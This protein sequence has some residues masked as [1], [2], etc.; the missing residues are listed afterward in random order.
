MR[1]QRPGDGEFNPYYATYIALVPDGDIVE[2]LAVQ[3][4][5]THRMLAATPPDLETYRYAPGK[6]SLRESLGHV[7]DTERVFT[8]RILWFSRGAED[9]LPGMDQDAWVPTSGAAERSLTD[10]LAEWQAVRG[11][12]VALL[13]GLPGEAWSR[14]GTASGSHVTV[15]ALAWMIAGHERHHRG[16]WRDAYGVES[17]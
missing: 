9:A 14:G 5:E 15:R 16:L 4:L 8:Q 2:T 11:G 10:Q 13:Q 6:W 17:P 1:A 7:I 3:W 12:L